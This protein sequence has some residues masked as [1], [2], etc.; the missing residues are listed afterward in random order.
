MILKNYA[1]DN[2]EKMFVQKN[3]N[4]CRIKIEKLEDLDFYSSGSGSGF[5]QEFV[6][7]PFL[8]DGYKFD[9]GIYNMITS[10]DPLRIHIYNGDLLL[11][12]SPKNIILIKSRGFLRFFSGIKNH[13]TCLQDS[14]PSLFMLK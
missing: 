6:H 10:I 8:I 9:I 7:D 14:Y 13:C 4:N 2:P 5:V 11:R 1:K 12:F 3:S